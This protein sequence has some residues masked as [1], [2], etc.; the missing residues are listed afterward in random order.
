MSPDADWHDPFAEDETARERERRRAE[1]EAAR[2]DAPRFGRREG[3]RAGGRSQRACATAAG[4]PAGRAGRRSPG[5]VAAPLTDE[6][7]TVAP[8][9]G[10]PRRRRP[11]MPATQPPAPPPRAA[12]P[13]PPPP[14]P[15]GE[16]L[17]DP[18][19]PAHRRRRDRAAGVAARWSIGVAKVDQPLFGG[20]DA[21][22]R[23]RSRKPVKVDEGAR[24]PRGY[25][26][27]QIADIAKKAGLKGDY[28]KASKSFKGFDPDEVRRRG[29]ARTS[30]GFSSRRP[31]TLPKHGTVKDL[32]SRQ[33][34]AFK[35]NIAGVD[36]SYAK[37]KNLTTYD[38]LKI[39]SMI[40]REV[41]VPKERPLVAEVIYNRLKAGTPLGI[42][43]TH[44]LLPAE[45]RR[46]S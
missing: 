27:H 11:A 40:E 31:T 25:D 13:A 36:M 14:A 28:K 6:P 17:A 33:L 42:D 37:S 1:R 26:R 12:R 30:R 20:N 32:I 41:Q 44:P 24:S 46:S 9:T 39:A 21:T 38:V 3:A 15:A 22:A 34:D 35:Q 7:E 4:T 19:G 16:A 5:A 23:R 29:A 2:R 18:F 43:A 10:D 8:V 45:L